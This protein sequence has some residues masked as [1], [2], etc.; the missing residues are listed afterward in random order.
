MS[1]LS[2]TEALELYRRADLHELGRLAHTETMRRHPGPVR[3]YIVDRNIN[4]TNICSGGC[5]FCN[6][7]RSAG[8][9]EGYVLGYDK[10]SAKI[11]EMVE[12]GGRQILLQGGMHPELAFDWYLTL[13]R[14]LKRDYPQVHI[15]GFSPPEIVHFSKQFG[16]SVPEILTDL[17]EA[18]LDTIPGGGAEILVD[19]VRKQLSPGKC[20]SDEWLAVMADA[21][22]LGMRTTATMMFGH[23]ETLEDRIEHLSRLRH[24]QDQTHGFTAFICWTFQPAGTRLAKQFGDDGDDTMNLAGVQDYLRMLAVSRLFLDNFDNLQASWVTQG[25]AV[26]QVA[27]HFGAN[28]FGSLMLEENV[29]ASAGTTYRLTERQLRR[30][31]E[32]AGFVPARR[33]CLYHVVEN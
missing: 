8:H 7:S 30:L 22:R 3:T 1:R 2:E 11:S 17:R 28:D 16:R 18:G 29:V 12:L 14:R 15:H 33:D 5:V 9:A 27:M 13:L 31:I 20:S 10:L 6:F 21:H 24:L 32:E 25:P 23:I 19:Y 4:Y 26:G